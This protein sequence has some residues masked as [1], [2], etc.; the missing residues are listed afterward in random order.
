[1]RLASRLA[2]AEPV[3]ESLAAYHERW[4]GTGPNQ[5]C[6]E[7]IPPAARILSVAQVV[8]SAVERFF[9]AVLS[10]L[11]LRAFQVDELLDGKSTVAAIASVHWLVKQTGRELQDHNASLP[12]GRGFAA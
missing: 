3:L 5:L 2:M 4:D 7:T 12:E 1:M 8:L 9:G 10:E 11:E 6:G